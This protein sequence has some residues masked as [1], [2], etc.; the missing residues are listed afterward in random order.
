MKKSTH[1]KQKGFW[2]RCFMILALLALYAPAPVSA[3]NIGDYKGK[4]STNGNYSMGIRDGKVIVW[5]N[6]MS[7]FG[8]VA[9]VPVDAQTDVVAVAA[10]LS[11][12]VALKSNGK[13]V[14]WPTLPSNG[15]GGPTNVPAD[16]TNV[17]AIAAG[18]NH[19]L[20]LT[21]N[22]KVVGWGG[23]AW[24]I[25]TVPNPPESVPIE[26]Q[27]DV[28]EIAAGGM[29]S[30][31]L[32]KNGSIV[33]WGLS[34]PP[35][36]INPTG[37]P[38]VDI[39]VNGSYLMA[40]KQ[41][42]KVAIIKDFRIF[43]PTS[44]WITDWIT[45]LT[46][47]KTIVVGMNHMIALK[48]DGTIVALDFNIPPGF[49]PI[50]GGPTDVPVGLNNVVAIA[51]GLNTTVALQADGTI[52][53]WGMNPFGMTDGFKLNKTT[54]T[55][56]VGKTD[57]LT[58]MITPANV[59]TKSVTWT[60]SNDAIASVSSDGTITAKKAGTAIITAITAWGGI[61][62][63]ATCTVTVQP[64]LSSLAID[65]GKLQPAFSP[66]TESYSVTLGS[67]ITSLTVTPSLTD[68]NDSLE[69]S[70][71]GTTTT[72][73][74]LS[75]VPGMNVIKVK[76]TSQDG[77]TSKTYT[78]TVNPQGSSDAT[79]NSLEVS[80]GTLSPAFSANTNSYNVN[81]P[82]DVSSIG[83]TATANDANAKVAIKGRETTA[84]TIT[85]S[86]GNNPIPVVVTAQD[87]VTSKTYT[88]TVVRAAATNGGS[89]GG[90]GGS[91]TTSNTRPASV[92]VGTNT[93]GTEAAQV[94]ITRTITA[95]GKK[96]DSVT[97]DAKKAA[98]AIAKAAANMNTLVIPIPD[99]KGNEAQQIVAN[100]PKD[101]LTKIA[102]SGFATQVITD[103]VTL[104][105][106]KETVAAL[107]K[108]DVYMKI[109]PVTKATEIQQT[110]ALLG[111]QAKDGSVI[112]TPL[113]IETNFSGRT[114]ITLPLTGMNIPTDAKK[115]EDFLQSLAIFIE[116]SDGEKKVDKG[117]IQYDEKH[118]PIGLSVWVDKFSTF[119]LVNLPKTKDDPKPQ[120]PVFTD[121]QGHWAQSRIQQLVQSGAVTGYPDGTFKP[122]KTITRAEFVAMVVK[123]FELQPQENKDIAF[124]DT[125]NHWAKEAIRTA[126]TNGIINGY[127]TTTF[128][129]NDTITREQM[130]VILTNIKKSGTEGKQVSF[131]DTA[132]IST[133]AQ[134]AVRQAVEEG[135]ITGYPNQT[136][137]PKKVATRAEAVTM[138]A[139]A[140]TI[141]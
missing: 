26:A 89:S 95:D 108:Q 22:G 56:T 29:Y 51:A 49:P 87:T 33:V 78:I 96:Q 139:N 85:L 1:K 131:K 37:S 71:N 38:V 4:I 107:T 55:L 60:S 5:G 103:K 66:D 14:A 90:G 27:T 109:E 118:N 58:A 93:K 120:A 62:N 80:T 111:V 54:T 68:T 116:H 94:S 9:D 86:V 77:T 91:S 76:A 13:V 20:A 81:V 123:A 98:E 124:T 82:N 114:K 134:K 11:Q 69:M 25:P 132:L 50:P 137:Q 104:E 59:I 6:A 18:E 127:N 72:A 10:G 70:L 125:K 92:L 53:T 24:G 141:K 99:L 79:L 126:Y 47:V 28:V 112:R 30:A 128:G 15:S 97:L 40:V 105:L 110:K 117:E 136:F 75:L 73:D 84:D 63:Q 133:W 23:I 36:V 64:T 129:A 135:I 130:A 42:G 138:I 102:D 88:I 100:L 21:D 34:L 12:A 46:D 43:P 41:D 119:T 35:E 48:N 83:I 16:L 101:A 2:I 57:T 44:P 115:Q 8:S 67:D 52:V 32:K 65:S 106:P 7:F 3:A 122:N 61:A 74:T 45:N 121:I 19:T 31:A 39:A 113:H 17:I 140:L